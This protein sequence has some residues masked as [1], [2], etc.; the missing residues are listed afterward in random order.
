MARKLP[1]L[2]IACDHKNPKEYCCPECCIGLCST[3]EVSFRLQVGGI[4]ITGK[5]DGTRLQENW[6][7]NRPKAPGETQEVR[8][9]VLNLDLRGE[10]TG[11]V[12]RTGEKQRRFGRKRVMRK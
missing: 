9:L 10:V 4:V 5:A 11:T 1:K 2:N 7:Y 6:R 8:R 12:T 3:H